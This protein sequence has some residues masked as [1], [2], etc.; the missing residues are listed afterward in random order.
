MIKT[1]LVTSLEKCFP[2]QH[3]DE[4][5]TLSELSA[6][7]GERISVQLIYRA[8][9]EDCVHRDWGKILVDGFGQSEVTVRTVECIPSLLPCYPGKSDDNFIKT[10]VGLYP[11][12]LLPLGNENRVPVVVNELRSVWI[13]LETDV[14]RIGVNRVQIK[15]TDLDGQVLA[16][17]DLKLEVL[18]ASLP[19]QE[20][21]VTQWFHGDCIAHYYDC[22]VFSAKW[23]KIVENF[24]KTAV[25]NGQN[26]LLTP[27]FTSPLDTEIGRERLTVQLVDV[28]VENGEYLF[29]YEKLDKWLAMCD[30]CGI[31]YYEISHLFTQWGAAHAPKIMAKVNGK[32]KRIFGWETD[33]AGEEY[34][35]FIRSF[36]IDFIAHMKKLGRD[37]LC[38]YH[39]SDEPNRDNL[40][41]Y[42][43]S[44]AVVADLL[45]DYNVADAL[46]HKEFYDSG[47]VTLPIVANDAIQ[48]FID[49]KIPRLW[50][51]YCCGQSIN[52]SNRFFAMPSCRNRCIGA[53]LFY[54]DIEG[55]LQWGYNF[56]SSYGSLS[57]VNPYLDSTG[58]YFVPSGD[59][60]SVYPAQNGE[61]Y[62][63]L[64]LAVFNEALQDLRAFRLCASLIGKEKTAEALRSVF[65]EIRFDRC[66]RT[67]KEVIE[68]REK[69][70]ALIKTQLK[71]NNTK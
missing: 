1:N 66:A 21:I 23:W 33:A 27:V 13:T 3:P 41:Q 17:H 48:P 42:V 8:Y 29:G 6:L 69:I 32:E 11:D 58:N 53:Q 30:R 14:S 68:A 51:Y 40:E 45:K 4:F 15:L 61:A 64:R 60:Y 28:T 54:Y 52:V 65:G 57:S 25:K 5:E 50:T 2:E 20:L 22:K 43:K 39:V 37:H 62:E 38:Y 34:S 31:K 70:N 36:L 7:V 16:S 56:Y 26:M 19:E 10:Q 59:A 18:P 63:S 46:S 49:A 67:A 47:A 24:V 44:K 55:F 9:G 35:K 71:N 12:L